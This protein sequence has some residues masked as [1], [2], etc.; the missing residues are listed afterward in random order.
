M[1]G[2]GRIM[3]D[4]G[5]LIPIVI[6]TAGPISWVATTWIRAR[7]GYPLTDREGDVREHNLPDAERHRMA[8]LAEENERQRELIAGLH[9]RLAV[10][11]RIATDPATRIAHDI[12]ALR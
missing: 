3:H 7:H 11:E 10:L 5:I 4:L 1:E 6:F 2:G 9:Q 8:V 12:D